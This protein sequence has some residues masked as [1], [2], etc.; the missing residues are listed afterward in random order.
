MLSTVRQITLNSHSSFLI[1][2]GVDHDWFPLL[3]M[4][5][6]EMDT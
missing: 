3:P 4:T 2:V 1:E 5:G 6:L